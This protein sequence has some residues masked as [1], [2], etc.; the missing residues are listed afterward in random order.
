MVFVILRV[1]Y[2]WG[3][4]GQAVFFAKQIRCYYARKQESENEDKKQLI[5]NNCL[6]SSG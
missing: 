5:I 4:P 3:K 1:E 2:L 6:F